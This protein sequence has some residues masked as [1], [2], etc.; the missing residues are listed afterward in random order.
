MTFRPLALLLA[1]MLPAAIANAAPLESS[2][3][4]SV[5]SYPQE[6]QRSYTIA[7]GLPSNDVRAIAVT[8]T[9]FVYAGTPEG[10]ARWNGSVWETVFR[11][12]GDIQKLL[13]DSERVY[14]VTNAYVYPV[15]DGKAGPPLAKLPA[16]PNALVWDRS[17]GDD[18]MLAA[19]DKGLFALKDGKATQI[20]VLDERYS[21]VTEIRDV[22]VSTNGLIVV[23]TRVGVLLL[24]TRDYIPPDTRESPQALEKRIRRNTEWQRVLPGD[25]YGDWAFQNAQAVYCSDYRPGIT[26]PTDLE[27]SGDYYLGFAGPQ[28]VVISGGGGDAL[29]DGS[30]G[31]P[32]NNF[33]SMD[34]VP[35][36]GLWLGTPKGVI[37]FHG[38]H[39][40]Y[41]AGKRW[42]P[43]DEVRDIAATSDGAWI[44]T[45]GGVSHIYYQPMTFAEKAK[46]F[47]DEI[48]LRH[49]RTPYEYVAGVSLEKP[50]DTSAWTQHD[51]DN[52]GQYTG[53]YGAAECFAYAATGDPIAKERATKAFEAL[54]FLS[55][56][57]QAGSNPAPKGFIARTILPTDGPNPNEHNSP[58]R[59]REK[60][61]SDALWKVIVPRWP[62]SG[63]GKWYWKTDASSDELDGHFLL[64]GLYYDHVAETDAEKARV[65]E[66]TAR[67]MDHLIEHDYKLVD[68]D[69]QPTRW[70][71]F[72]PESLNGDPDW[73]AERGLN[74]LSLLTY[75]N[76]A[77]HVTGDQKY[78][79]VFMDLVENHHY[80]MNGMVAPKL[81]A[82]PGSYVQFDD[83]MAFMNYYNLI[84]YETDPVVL[85]M[86][87]NS[88]FY[89]WQIEKYERNPFFNFVYAALCL[90][91]GMQT[92]WGV[93][94]LS[95]T[96]AWLKDSV[97]WLKRF[98]LNQ[99]MWSVENSHRIDILPLPDHVREPGEAKGN[100]YRVDGYVI[101]VDE[102]NA[103]SFSEDPWRLDEGGNGTRLKDGAPFLLAYYL[104]LYHGFIV[105]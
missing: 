6:M 10:L 35:M 66:V 42:L 32:Y 71:N 59:D 39:W 95:P 74:S 100:G 22:T 28:G 30:A 51:T 12:P 4:I 27:G 9:G 99:I 98:P 53:L 20:E 104:G 41:R 82:G 83:K 13:Y 2:E 89:Y 14:A 85:R 19:T 1:A 76:V 57:T 102:R 67:V 72:S 58:E 90:G 84:R 24:L 64:Y 7:D 37:H 47:E 87:Q 81:Q 49:R 80:A 26:A 8:P 23:A 3:S 88:I 40:A 73:W 38:G 62:T 34:I 50:G 29:Y 94:D 60:Q 18:A 105:E 70:A 61:K 36:G 16:P 75:L 79:D 86:F 93:T 43:D 68:H 55:E 91:Q 78:R 101:P 96:G 45:A 46:Y 92:Q 52:D 65:R 11:A 25:N 103:M 21:E 69:G 77:W 5:G 44:A 63:D 54:A 33:T 97:D 15:I 31:L 56:V 17:E 48:D